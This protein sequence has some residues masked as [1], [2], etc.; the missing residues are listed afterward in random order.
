MTVLAA[1]RYRDGKRTR[2][3][4]LDDDVPDQ[5]DRSEFAWI[6]L[7]DPTAAELAVLQDRYDLPP[8]MVRAALVADQPPKL[9]VYG[10]QLLVIAR[11]ARIEDDRILYGALA[12]FVSHHH[13]I[14]VHRGA[15]S[16]GAD[17]RD[18]LE[19]APR[20]L[21]QGVDY[22][23][24][25]VLNTVVDEYLPIFEMVEDDVL[26]MEH[27]S[28]DSFIGREGVVR[29]FHLRCE[30][31]RFQR[32]LGPMGEVIRKLV[33][34]HY[35]CI[36]AVARPYFDDVMDHVTRVQTM[37]DGLLLVLV[38]VF[39]LS[40]LLEQ[41]RTGAITRQL[42]AWAAIL[43]V[44]TAVAGIYGMNFRY[45]PELELRYGYFGV[46]GIMAILC[47]LLWFRFRRAKWL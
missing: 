18:Q 15:A 13:I 14:I 39:E 21:A 16:H 47:G 11:S 9:D 35:P 33:R 25:A 37:V 22:V 42:A 36:S 23:L 32:T 17:L 30:L 19:T 28:L 29:I 41:Q 4:A 46:M 8:L 44:P 2:D 34:G 20:L 31:T 24:H 6:D 40:S 45:M 43:A 10:H 38:S 12:V 5:M 27:R 1:C 3:I 7:H 26:Q